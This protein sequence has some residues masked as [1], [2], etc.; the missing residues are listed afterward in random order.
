MIKW[1]SLF[2]VFQSIIYCQKY[3]LAEL[4]I[5]KRGTD[6]YRV[7]IYLSDKNGSTSVE[8]SEKTVFR[9]AKNGVHDSNLWYDLNIS[10]KYINHL[11]SLGINVINESRW[12]N[13]VSALCA[14]SDLIKIANLSFVDK[15]KPVVGYKRTSS[16]EYPD[17]ISNS[18]DF[19]YGNALEQIEQINVHEL[20]EQGFTG[21]GVRILVMDT[22]FS[23][24]H[25]SLLGINVVEEWDVIKGDQITA[26]ETQE[27]VAVNQDYHG[28]AVLSTIASNVS[29]EFIGAAFDAEFLLAKT[30]DVSQEVQLEEDN[31][32]AGLEWGEEN[33]A[34]VVSTSLGYLD[35]YEY[36]DMDGNTAVTTIG[37]DIAVSLGVVCVTAAGNSGSSSWYYIIAPADAD[38][39]ISVGAVDEHGTI[40]TFSSHGPTS[41]GRTKP[42]VCARGRQTWC[43]NPNSNT[44]Y[45]RLS[46]TSLAC[47]L[48][49]GA[50]ALIIQAR[51]SW[52]AMEVREAMMM[53]ASNADNPDNTYGYG[54]LNAGEA[55][56]YGTTSK[57]D[58]ANYLPID[59]DLVRAYP[60][61]FNPSM[62]IE[63]DVLSLSELK[64]DIFSYNGSHVANIFDGMTVNQL[65]RF[66]W[67]PKNMPSAV[68][69]VRLIINGKINYK[70][71]T[72]IK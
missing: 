15:I 60:N 11:S 19:D 23:L 7:W 10:S 12:L 31:Y 70:K 50:A 58:N 13:A 8:I 32:V 26:D 25:N 2:L 62:N 51:P 38:S 69:V 44:N 56:N 17:I 72:F 1:L 68:Y 34:D 63:I 53:T 66:R 28:T 29:G 42:E 4:D 40:T 36:S 54:I 41:D 35:W 21:S 64:V 3:N 67:E 9:R 49:A 33:G 55:I 47:P 46:G 57:N 22:G 52:S 59:Y 14:K 24:T 71:V 37:I 27:E 16:F 65:S 20:H 18:R 30:E 5:G 45:S 6:S 48:V 61:P 43:V 39:V